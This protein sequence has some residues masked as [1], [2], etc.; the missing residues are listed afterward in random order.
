M[1]AGGPFF[2]VWE[3]LQG[4]L[5][6][7]GL[8]TR[9]VRAKAA[10]AGE[11]LKEFLPFGRAAL[12]V[13]AG[14]PE[15]LTES[16]RASLRAYRP[17]CILAEGPDPIMPLFLLPDDVRAVVAV[18]PRSAL[19]ARF[20]RT[21]RGGF[22][23]LLPVRPAADELFAAKAPPPWEG[24]PLDEPDLVLA[25]GTVLT[26]AAGAL[27]ETALAALCAEELELDA[28]F[29]ESGYEQGGLRRAA[30]LA[31]EANILLPEGREELLAASALF[32]LEKRSLP[33]FG[34]ERAA[35]ALPR[36]AAAVLAYFA[37]RYE[38]LF[39]RGRPR[40]YYVPDYVS[41]IVRAAQVLEL[42]A[43]ALFS[44]VRVPTGEQSF[45]LGVRFAQVR[46]KLLGSVRRVSAYAA[47]I[48]GRLAAAGP[49]EGVLSV[50]EQRLAAVYDAS[51]EASPLLTAPALE[52]EFGLLPPPDPVQ[53]PAEGAK[54]PGGG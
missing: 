32:C 49:K 50:P 5:R 20:F 4:A 9:F 24:Y 36:G 25:D 39:A 12:V 41:R 2:V 34:C 22:A 45:R 43:S 18:G 6:R 10:E 38:D 47:E 40:P 27:A 53:T 51:A 37:R 11:R 33:P 15:T 46:E 23:V 19:A 1:Y 48:G 42:P 54:A 30:Q 28:A 29:A 16:V 17:Q 13:D 3:E 35:R 8:R 26:A 52:R 31:A 44:N 21:L 7:R 14:T